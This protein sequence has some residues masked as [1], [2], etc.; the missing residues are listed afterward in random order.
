MPITMPATKPGS[1]DS[2]AKFL[3]P[4]ASAADNGSKI[5]YLL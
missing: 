5:A 2:V 1:V 3:F 4:S